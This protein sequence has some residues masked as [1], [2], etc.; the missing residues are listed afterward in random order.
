VEALNS[1]IGFFWKVILAVVIYAIGLYLASLAYKAILATGTN[2][3]NFL[4]RL[5]QFAVIVFASAIAL[6]EV[7]VADDIINLAFGIV[8]GAIG[9]AVALAFG[10]GS[11]QIA[12][13]EADHFISSLRA[14]NEKISCR[15]RFY[16]MI[17]I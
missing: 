16:K 4:G 11:Q 1:F 12:G 3:T 14:P 8:L 10:L 9:V 17:L 7:G 13:C 6:R 2:Q 5:A 15:S